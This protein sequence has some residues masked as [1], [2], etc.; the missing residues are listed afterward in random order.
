[1]HNMYIVP[2]GYMHYLSIEQYNT[3]VCYCRWF[4]IHHSY[5]FS[6]SSAA[7]QVILLNTSS[8]LLSLSSNCVVS[9]LKLN[10]EIYHLL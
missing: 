10:L 4:E 2:V 8:S 1:M 6:I 5:F 7:D 3:Q 9:F